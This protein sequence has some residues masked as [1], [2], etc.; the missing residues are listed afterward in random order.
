MKCQETE[1][2]VKVILYA[3]AR[4][5]F[6]LRRS[7]IA[8]SSISFACGFNAGTCFDNVH[9]CHLAPKGLI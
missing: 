1:S 5:I 6:R 3:S 7:F 9:A 4:F 2:K 8:V